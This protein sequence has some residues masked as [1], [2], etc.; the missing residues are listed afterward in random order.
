MSSPFYREKRNQFFSKVENFWPDL[1]GEEYA[2]YDIYKSNWKAVRK[3][4]QSTERIG[5][6][7]FKTAKLL[8]QAPDEILIDMG[9]PYKALSFLRLHPLKAESVISRLDLVQSGN[10]FKCL[11]LN[12]DTPTFIKEVFSVNELICNDFKL[13]NPNQG[14]ESV[15]S[16]AVNS[17]ICQVLQNQPEKP[18]NIVFT[19]HDDHLEDLYTSLYLQGLVKLPSRFIPLH[20][21]HIVQGEGLFDEDGH[22]ISV[23]YRQTFPIENL[24]LD[25][26]HTGQP[27]GLWLLEL[28]ELGKLTIINPPSAFLLQNKAVQAI[29]WGLHEENNPFFTEEEH[30]WIDEHFLPTYLEQDP[31][32]KAGLP[33]VKKPVFGRE[34]DTVEIYDGNGALKME[35][36][37]KTYQDYL[38]IYQQYIDLPKISY[39]SEKGKSTGHMIF[40]SFLIAGKAGA[41]G[42]RVGNPITNN[43]SYFLPIG[44]EG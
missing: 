22:P 39:N 32:L 33:F 36:S 12:S 29:I 34:G 41:I 37:Y 5:H 44:V 31:F 16:E 24:L 42:C 43:L 38:P 25:H 3:I 21:L 17:Y 18:L 2:L 4:Q 40:G 1:Y 8:R 23:L 7:F 6:I 19:A 27:I 11:E 9:F 35:D 10:T 20:Q 30:K 14:I 28:V 13:E 15:L 26:D